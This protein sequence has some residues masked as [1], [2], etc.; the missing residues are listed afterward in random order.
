MSDLLSLVEGSELGTSEWILIDQ[1]KI[2]EFAQATDDHQWI[3]VDEKRCAKESPFKSTIAHGFLSATLMPSVFYPMLEMPPGNHSLLNYG[4]DNIRF[5]EAVRV[6][7]R[8]RYQIKLASREAKATGYLFR[9]SCTVEIENREK[10][11][12]VGTFLTLLV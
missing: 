6:N 2:N 8:I 3:H 7:D 4:V 11:A 5:L 1:Q 12:M 10:P 9:F